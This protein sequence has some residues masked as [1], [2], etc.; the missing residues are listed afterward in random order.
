MEIV[1]S[2]KT[3]HIKEVVLS[4]RTVFPKTE[5]G[6][7]CLQVKLRDPRRLCEGIYA[8]WNVV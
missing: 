7:P 8:N 5:P 3:C 2:S 1:N 6:S 4:S